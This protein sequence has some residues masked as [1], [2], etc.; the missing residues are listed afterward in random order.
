MLLLLLSF[1]NSLPGGKFLCHRWTREY[2]QEAPYGIEETT[3]NAG[4]KD[5]VGFKWIWDS[6]WVFLSDLG[7]V[8]ELMDL[9]NEHLSAHYVREQHC[10]RQI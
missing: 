9:V 1:Q 6:L 10:P 4:K 2:D 8:T 3:W 5:G 7:Q